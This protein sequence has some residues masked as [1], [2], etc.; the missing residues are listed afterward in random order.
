MVV[1][2]CNNCCRIFF[3]FI[4]LLSLSVCVCVCV[5]VFWEGVVRLHSAT[6]AQ[7]AIRTAQV[8]V[9]GY[10]VYSNGEIIY[11][12]MGLQENESSF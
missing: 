3:Y 6:T 5:C 12:N 11:L 1:L 8:G 4:R 10:V 9:G 2:I 7:E